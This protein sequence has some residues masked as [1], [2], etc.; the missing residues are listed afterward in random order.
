MEKRLEG[1][2]LKLEGITLR[3]GIDRQRWSKLC[4]AMGQTDPDLFTALETWIY[5]SIEGLEKYS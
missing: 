2:L 1:V 4:A 5:Q 3:E